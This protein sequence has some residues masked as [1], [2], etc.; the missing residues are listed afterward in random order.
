[1]ALEEGVTHEG[2][3]DSQANVSDS[4]KTGIAA[5]SA[6]VVFTGGACTVFLG[7]AT[8]LSPGCLLYIVYTSLGV[9]VIGSVWTSTYERVPGSS[10]LRKMAVVLAVTF[11]L[12]V[13][14]V[15][16]PLT[17]SLTDPVSVTVNVTYFAA[18]AFVAT[19]VIAYTYSRLNGTTAMD[20]ACKYC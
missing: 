5:G 3:T 8:A 18:A 9:G 7:L 15:L 13:S 20:I 12:F 11:A 10:M 17:P 6:N 14:G 16:L 4:S 19:T 1:M 2:S